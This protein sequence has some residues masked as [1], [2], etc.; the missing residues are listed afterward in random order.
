MI[1]LIGKEA[2]T[3]EE[4]KTKQVMSKISR[5]ARDAAIEA[6]RDAAVA[7]IKEEISEIFE[8]EGPRLKKKGKRL[9]G[10]VSFVMIGGGLFLI[11]K[12]VIKNKMEGAEIIGSGKVTLADGE[13]ANGLSGL[14]SALATNLLQNPAKREI[15][16]QM[17]L[18]ISIQDVDNADNATTLDFSGSDIYVSNGV[19]PAA[20]V[21]IVA[22]LSVLLGLGAMGKGLEALK[23]LNS[24]EGKKLIDALKNG[25]LK[26]SGAA[27]KPGDMKRFQQFLS[28]A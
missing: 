27:K 17:R 19:N 10:L 15:A 9:G 8:Q 3:T 6:A 22:D 12:K 5:N 13:N 16:G 14:V 11:A 18:V 4:T 28:P 1:R 2:K 26:V 24:E 7:S 20:D 23:F 21:K 25:R